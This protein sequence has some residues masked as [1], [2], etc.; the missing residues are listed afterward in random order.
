MRVEPDGTG[1]MIMYSFHDK[2]IKVP[3]LRTKDYGQHW[4]VVQE[5]AKSNKGMQPTGMKREC[6][7]QDSDA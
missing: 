1:V 4:S 2:D 7:P 3:E 5:A 6:H